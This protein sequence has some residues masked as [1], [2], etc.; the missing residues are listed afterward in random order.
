MATEGAFDLITFDGGALVCDM[1]LDATATHSLQLSQY[2]VEDGTTISDHAIHDPETLNLTLVQTQTP[3]SPVAG[4]SVTTSTIPVQSKAMG[5]QSVELNVRQRTGIPANVN[6]LIGGLTARVLGAVNTIRIEGL[7][8]DLAPT[9]K[10]LQIQA[11]TADSPVERVNDFYDALLT[12]LGGVTPVVVT[13]KG[14][15]HI[16]MIFTSVTRT[17]SPGQNGAA[18]FQVS[19]QRVRTVITQ[20][21]ELPPVPEATRK[22]SRAAKP[23]KP[24]TPQESESILSKGFDAGV[25]IGAKALQVFE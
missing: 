15:S 10:S 6:Q 11:L 7:K 17:D 16:D 8:S 4:F 22:K 2:P 14:V 1:L 25:D 24:V 19:L 9:T 18:R 13:V 12:L 23:A 21:V 20:T 3:I 5:K